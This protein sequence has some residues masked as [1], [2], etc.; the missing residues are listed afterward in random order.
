MRSRL[1]RSAPVRCATAGSC[2]V[3]AAIVAASLADGDAGGVGCGHAL[4]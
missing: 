4:R 2:L 3:G 1:W